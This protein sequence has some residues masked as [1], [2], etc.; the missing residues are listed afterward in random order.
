VAEQT[1]KIGRVCVTSISVNVT[2]FGLV[3]ISAIDIIKGEIDSNWG[4]VPPL[5]VAEG[6]RV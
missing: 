2:A 5:S 1:N 6:I 3:H 4:D